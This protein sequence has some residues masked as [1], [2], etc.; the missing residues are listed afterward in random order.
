MASAHARFCT[1]AALRI[2]RCAGFATSIAASAWGLMGCGRCAVTTTVNTDGSFKRLAV[3]SSPKSD[4][5][6]QL[7]F[8]P[9]LEDVF[10]LPTGPGVNVVK[11]KTSEE[12]SYRATRTVAA[13]QGL[14]GDV[15]VRSAGP[16]APPLCTNEVSVRRI[17]PGKLEYTETIHWTG[18]KET[19]STPVKIL[20]LEQIVKGAL[21][22]ELA[23]P[24]NVHTVG[25]IVM[26]EFFHMLFG[27]PEP[28]LANLI[29]NLLSFPE[30]AA[31]QLVKDVGPSI[32]RALGEKFGNRFPH[33]ER[34]KFMR[35][36]AD[37]MIQSAK[38]S[39]EAKTTADQPSGD[40]GPAAALSF[41]VR[42]PGKV[43][44]TNGEYDEYTGDVYWAL[45]PDSA[46]LGDIVLR[47][48]CDTSAAARAAAAK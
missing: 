32:D 33:G 10:V 34:V 42:M 48:V 19:K 29:T 22:A 13:G 1:G 2:V 30:V 44:E 11:T 39:A 5:P 27:P 21:P 8:A 35:A 37:A 47:A 17:A 15:T 7:N 14:K 38:T 43:V 9:K 25:Q 4:K 3:Y 40:T 36:L 28:K 20:E 18:P 26:R 31:H 12:I 45:Y 24:E 23:T 6:G 46:A 41:L 16:N